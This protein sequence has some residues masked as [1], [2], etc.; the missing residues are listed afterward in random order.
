MAKRRAEAVLTAWIIER[1]DTHDEER[2]AA[3]VGHIRSLEA[4]VDK[5]QEALDRLAA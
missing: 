2:D 1:V 4:K 5:L 3:T